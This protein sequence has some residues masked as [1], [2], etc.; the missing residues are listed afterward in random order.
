MRN[1]FIL[2]LVSVLLLA[3]CGTKTVI[4]PS[5]N[6]NNVKRIGIMAF[7]SPW[8]AFQGTENTFAKY[9]LES[10]FIVV[11]RAKIEQ[12]LEEHNLS[13]TGYLSPETTKMLGKIL[14]VDLL[15]MGEITNYSPEKK[16]LT[17]VETRNYRTDPVYSTQYTKGPDGQLTVSSRPVGQKVTRQSDVQPS[18]Y[19]INAQVGIVAKLVDVQTAEIVWI[20]T[21][22]ASSSNSLTAVDSI[23]KRLIKSFNKELKNQKKYAAQ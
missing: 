5:Y 1:I 13:I 12:V 14:G 17:M 21:D 2:S 3:A 11:E 10:G 18:E 8:Q 23:A 15:L 7:D 9:L 4:S 19:T 6:F 22:T 16:T 20:G